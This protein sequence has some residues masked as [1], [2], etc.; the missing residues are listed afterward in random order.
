MDNSKFKTKAGRNTAYAM[1]CGYI[2]TLEKNGYRL[3]AWHEGACYHVRMHCD[4]TDNRERQGRV[5]WDSF[6]TL[7]ETRKRF[8]IAK[9]FIKYSK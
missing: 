8:D 5:F 6:N 7:T 2:E 1:A 9:R 4:G 3:T